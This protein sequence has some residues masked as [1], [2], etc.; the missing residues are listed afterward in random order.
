MSAHER[1]RGLV[2]DVDGVLTDGTV[3]ISSSGE[4]SK[5]F[6]VQDGTGFLWCRMLG[7]ELA[8][9]SGRASG[10]T[11][12]RAE[13]L[14]I[15]EV[16][17]GVRDKL[18]QVTRWAGS[19]GLALD[20]VLYMG[21]DHIDLPVFEAVGIPVAPANADPVVRARAAHVTAARGG[22]GAVREAI[23]WLLDGAGRLAEARAAYRERVT[24]SEES[25]A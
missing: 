4:E 7:Y 10:A 21:D 12:I 20:E 18:E 22:E 11:S 15:R 6:S 2:F 14:G 19:K 1:I 16:Y 23:E 9:V 3:S 25:G 13:E 5:R 8:L 17:Q 24:R